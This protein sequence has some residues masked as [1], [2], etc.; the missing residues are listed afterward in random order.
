MIE[1]DLRW[2][3]L[4]GMDQKAYQAWA[5]KAIGTVLQSPGLIEFRANRSMLA[6]PFIR[7]TSVW[8]TMA[9]WANFAG[10]AA[11]LALREELL[12]QYGQD[13]TVEV[14]GPSPVIPEPLRPG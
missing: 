2:N 7:T 8:K 4:P 14:W 12:D 11:W 13:F 9:D 1:V 3:P 6:E 5:K 10:S